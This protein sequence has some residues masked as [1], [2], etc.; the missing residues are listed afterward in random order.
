MLRNKKIYSLLLALFMV[1]GII[2]PGT[3]FADG[4]TIN[5]TV[6]GTTD[7][8]ANIY[9]WSYED[10][11]ESEDIGMTKVFSVIQKIREENPNTILID[12][13]D[14][15]QGTILSDDLYNTREDLANPVID[16]MNFMKYDAMIL[17]NHEFNFGIDLIKKIEKEAEFPLLAAN[18]TYKEDG[19]YLVKPYTVVEVSGVKVGI[20]G[21][22]N[23]NIPKWDGPKVT[24]L[25]FEDM[26]TAA[27]KHIK[28]LKEVEKVDVIIAS[29]HAGF[30]TEYGND[31]AKA[32]IEKF[33]EIAA[34]MVGHGHVTVNEKFGN[35]VVGAARDQGRQVVRFDLNLKK[36]NDNWV[37]AD[38][39]VEIIEVK[40]YEAS[41]ELVEHSKEAHEKTLEFLEEVIGTAKEDFHPESEIKGIPEAQIRDTAVM[42]LINNIQLEATGADVAGAA[43]F[44]SDSN[45]KAGNLT[46]ASIFDIYKYPNTLV[47]IEINGEQLKNYM[48]W[49]AKYYNTFTPGDINISFNPDI[50]GYNYDMF[51]GVDYKVDISKPEGERI[52]DLRFNGELVKDTDIFKLAVNNYRYGGLK[53]MGIIDEDL[54]PYFESDP[55]ALR[56]YI[57]EY[58]RENKEII[59]EIDNNWEVVGIDLNHPLRDYLIGEINKGSLE[60][61]VSEDG[62][63]YNAKAINAEEMIKKGLIP[64]EVLKEHNIVVKEV[65]EPTEKLKEE[66]AKTTETTTETQEQPEPKKYTVKSGD[67]LWRIA[68]EFNTT[69][70]ELAKFN[71]LKNPNLI[72]PNQVILVP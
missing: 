72:F 65:V 48:E 30:E 32:I 2:V 52:V 24:E 38:N 37:L 54:E 47:G 58:I 69:W 64:E 15:I 41:K 35:T 25:K 44:K 26:A 71:S 8:H 67:V 36:E 68:K 14:T 21:F 6:L 63:S 61:P 18:A 49:S 60:L 11:V 62:R 40:E 13:G 51:Q 27:E 17:G 5:I 29:A 28:E 3:A 70:Q 59:P 56:T 53:S 7:L 57:A 31:G 10:G 22:T 55:K 66:K 46:Y 45:L 9:N 1:F 43:L 34:L 33:P 39:K 16:A 50:R 12:N 23:P 19:S 42:D 4:E 20:L